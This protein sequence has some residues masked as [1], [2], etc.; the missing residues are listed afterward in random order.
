VKVGRQGPGLRSTRFGPKD[1]TRRVVVRAGWRWPGGW[2]RQALTAMFSPAPQ[3]V[4]SPLHRASQGGH[5]EV[6]GAL[7]AK[8]ADVEAKDN[9]SIARACALCPS[10]S[11]TRMQ[12]AYGYL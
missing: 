5:L 3:D 12:Y 8:S 9:V 1:D 6:V 7:L 2:R 11:L 4:W 10:R